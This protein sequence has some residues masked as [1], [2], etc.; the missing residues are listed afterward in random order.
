MALT[1]QGVAWDAA[2]V[3]ANT[4]SGSSVSPGW[5]PI[6]RYVADN[7]VRLR[8]ERGLSTTR[9]ASRLEELGNPIPATGITRIEKGQRRVDTDDLVALADALNVSPTT[10]L[11]PP[12]FGDD[13]VR[14]TKNHEVTSRTAWRWAEGRQPAMDWKPGEGTNL[15]S[16]S[17]DP[18]IETEAYEREQEYGRRRIEY[19]ALALP[20]ELQRS[21]DQPSVRLAR[22]LA[23]LVEDLAAPDAGAGSSTE[24]AHVRT[25]L[26]RYQQLGL[27]LDELQERHAPR[28]GVHPG[29]QF[30]RNMQR[31][32]SQ[33]NETGSDDPGGK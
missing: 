28:P 22:E 9:L 33:E 24:A 23:E 4:A 2:R 11:L 14:L 1:M 3:T 12:T 15:A 16:P 30:Q 27:E 13:L 6:S 20:A 21:A 25:A 32:E 17:A 5:G 7:L 31:W 10:L 8:Q 26:R 18:T 29:E 19:M